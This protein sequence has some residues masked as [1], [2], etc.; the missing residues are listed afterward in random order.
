MKN[1]TFSII[2]LLLFS[3]AIYSQTPDAL[4]KAGRA[5]D[6]TGRF[7]KALKKFDKAILLKPDYA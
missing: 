5:L 6:S 4:L 3:T 1:K 2:L 7:D